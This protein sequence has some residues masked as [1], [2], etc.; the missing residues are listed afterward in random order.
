MN[1]PWFLYPWFACT[2]LVVWFAWGKRRNV[3]GWFILGLWFGPIALFFL[4]KSIGNSS[5]PR[6]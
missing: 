3:F 4:L 1:M 6:T 5:P 2:A